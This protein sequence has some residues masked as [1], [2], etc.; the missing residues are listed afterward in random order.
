MLA[1]LWDT[2]EHA[3]LLYGL[4][5]EMDLVMFKHDFQVDLMR[6][7]VMVIKTLLFSHYHGDNVTCGGHC[8]DFLILI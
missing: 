2:P 1:V 8:G 4:L 5:Y 3:S 7:S 6:F